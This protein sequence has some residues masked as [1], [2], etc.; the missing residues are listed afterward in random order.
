MLIPA[1]VYELPPS[2]R[3]GAIVYDG[4]VD[5][6]LWR[7]PGP[8]R[9]LMQAYGASLS[10]VLAKERGQLAGGQLKLGQA[11]RLHPG[12]LRCD[13]LIW[14]A[15]RPAHGKTEPAAAPDLAAIEQLAHAALALACKHGTLR[16]AFGSAGA[17]NKAVDG[18]ERLA[19][20]VRG[21]DAFRAQRL[22]QSKA[23]PVEETLV[24]AASAAEVAK[25]RRL[26]ARL[27][28]H[29]STAPVLGAAARSPAGSARSPA[30]SARSPAGSKRSPA[31]AVRS[32]SGSARSFA[33]FGTMRAHTT[34]RRSSRSRKLDPAEIANAHVRAA[35]Y[36][37]GRSYIEGEWF[38]HPSFGAGQV[39]AVQG[40]ERMVMALFED[41]E[42]RRLI[43]ARG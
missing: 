5:L 20:L 33:G 28:K 43:H 18:G 4:T 1:S 25:A 31:G 10:A 23:V 30:G 7:P 8:D 24:C 13:Y 39:Q 27:A 6:G 38:I 9:D 29:A 11:L 21:A 32:P 37:R 41:G 42:E 36:D 17:G 14:V 3:A 26:T 40:P 12:K 34:A 35:T 15:S 2:Q 19:A 16:V 22:K